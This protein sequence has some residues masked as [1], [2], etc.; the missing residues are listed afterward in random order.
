MRRGSKAA[1]LE[2][3]AVEGFDRFFAVNVRA[4]FFLVQQI[5]GNKFDD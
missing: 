5:T 2:D 1:T 4:P 3:T